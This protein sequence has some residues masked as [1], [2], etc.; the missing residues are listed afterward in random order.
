MNI[1]VLIDEIKATVLNHKLANEGEYCR[2]LWQ[3]DEKNRELG[4]NEYG[5]ADAINIL[6]TINDF[7][8]G[9]E[10][11]KA[12]IKTLQSLQDPKTGLFREKTHHFI[13]TTAHCTAALELLDARPLYKF[14][15]LKEYATP[16]GLVGLLESLDWAN[17][18]WSQSHRGAGIYAALKLNGEAD[19]EWEE[20]YFNWLWENADPD[21]GFWKKGYVGRDRSLIYSSMA[22]GFHYMFNIEY[23]KRPLRYPEKIVDTCLDIYS[24][25]LIGK[26]GTD[27][28]NEKFGK[29]IAFLEIDWIYTLNRSLRQTGYR[30]QDCIEALRK[31]SKEYIEWLYSIDYKTHDGFNDLH[32]L[33]GTCCALA[34]LQNALL[35]EI[36]TDK[37]MRLVLDRRPFI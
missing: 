6:Y 1:Q 2:Y 25:K 23:A 26:K 33:F 10:S 4:V 12:H 34:E 16:E 29:Y 35:G 11:R 36:E 17:D 9:E 3:N 31:F 28:D 8:F 27:Y 20:T 22:G 21:Y 18:P 24:N 14:E 5:C 30:R 32:M 13:H 15:A 37:P 7:A 19:K